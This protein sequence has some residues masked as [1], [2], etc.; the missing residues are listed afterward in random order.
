MA[1]KHLQNIWQ[2]FARAFPGYLLAATTSFFFTDSANIST[3]YTC[4]FEHATY[5]LPFVWRC[6]SNRNVSATKQQIDS[7]KSLTQ[8]SIVGL[9]FEILIYY[10]VVKLAQQIHIKFSLKWKSINKMYSVGAF[11]SFNQSIW[12][13]Q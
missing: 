1:H 13:K 7:K 4:H 12:P 3:L 11:L 6:L 9:C 10:F 2:T 5:D 8:Y